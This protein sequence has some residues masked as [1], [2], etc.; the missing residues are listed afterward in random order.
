[1]RAISKSKLHLDEVMKKGR[2]GS[3]YPILLRHGAGTTGRQHCDVIC[4][5]RELVVEPRSLKPSTLR[6]RTER[7]GGIRRSTWR[8]SKGTKEREE[9][10]RHRHKKIVHGGD[11]LA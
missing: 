10:I 1:M 8:T 6:Q 11:P 3:I 4:W 9:E 7:R 2:Q 5:G